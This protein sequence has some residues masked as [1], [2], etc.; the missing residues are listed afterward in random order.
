MTLYG[1]LLRLGNDNFPTKVPSL[2]TLIE[3][4]YKKTTQYG[5]TEWGDNRAYYHLTEE[6][7]NVWKELEKKREEFF[8]T[9]SPSAHICDDA[10]LDVKDT[11]HLALSLNPD[12]PKEKDIILWLISNRITIEELQQDPFLWKIIKPLCKVTKMKKEVVKE[13]TETSYALEKKND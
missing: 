10:Y 11:Y 5:L 1:F 12:D 6:Q 9:I 2:N 8:L 13:V 4:Y 3:G 7:A